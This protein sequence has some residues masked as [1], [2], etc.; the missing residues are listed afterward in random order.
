MPDQRP[1]FVVLQ[2]GLEGIQIH[3]PWPSEEIAG[4]N[5]EAME[6]RWQ[7]GTDAFWVV[8]VT[9]PEEERVD[10]QQLFD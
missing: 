9:P 8:E 6:S 7:T 3:G 1:Q 5:L 4:D 10:T 2:I